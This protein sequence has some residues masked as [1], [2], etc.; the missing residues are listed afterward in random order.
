MAVPEF[1]SFMLPVLNLF[2]D[3]NIHTTSECMDVAINYFK[4][5]ILKERPTKKY[6]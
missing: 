5:D 4:L 6:D 2:S 1:Q 3:N